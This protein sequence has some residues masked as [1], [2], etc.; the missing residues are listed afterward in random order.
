MIGYSELVIITLIILSNIMW[1][2]CIIIIILDSS[3]TKAA[4][5]AWASFVFF[6]HIFGVISYVI[7]KS[8]KKYREN[9]IQEV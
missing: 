1:I 7:Y 2:T 3:I 5:I 6:T 8:V 9:I 4:K